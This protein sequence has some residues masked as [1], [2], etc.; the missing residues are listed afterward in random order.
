MRSERNLER[1]KNMS[2]TDIMREEHGVI[3]RVLRCL[4]ASADQAEKEPGLDVESIQ[5]MLE[6]FRVLLTVVIMPRKRL[7]S[8]PWRVSAASGARRQASIACSPNTKRAA[9]TSASWMRTY[10][11]REAGI[12]K[13]KCASFSTRGNTCSF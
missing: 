9:T 13:P 1:G 2:A 3:L 8:F 6:F 7:T 11:R 10:P 4:S 12:D 5:K